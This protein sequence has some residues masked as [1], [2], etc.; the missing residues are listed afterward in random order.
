MKLNE[1]IYLRIAEL[2][3]SRDLTVY[4]LAKFSGVPRSTISTMK[5]SKSIGTACIYDICEYL[6]IS[7]TEFFTSPLFA[8]E[9][10][11]D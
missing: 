6:E 9:N 1:A 3:R 4:K 11:M 2:A 5:V 8:R 7:L 10:L